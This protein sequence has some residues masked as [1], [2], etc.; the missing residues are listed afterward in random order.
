MEK[1]EIHLGGGGVKEKRDMEK[2]VYC[3]PDPIE[4]SMKREGLNVGGVLGNKCAGHFNLKTV[5]FRETLASD[6]FLACSSAIRVFFC[7][8]LS[9]TGQLGQA[10]M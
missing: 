6:N 2:G 3:L 4:N 1:I 5:N 8:A 10:F 7:S 9:T